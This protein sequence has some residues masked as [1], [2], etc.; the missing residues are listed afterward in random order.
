MFKIFIKMFKI[1]KYKNILK[2]LNIEMFKNK[3][4]K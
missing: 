1:F 2:Y 3:A 4:R